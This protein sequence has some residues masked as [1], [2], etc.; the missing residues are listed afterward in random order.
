MLLSPEG[1]LFVV[2]NSQPFDW[3]KFKPLQNLL[4]H[5]ERRSGWRPSFPWESKTPRRGE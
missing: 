1:V 3:R 2:A 5:A 4:S